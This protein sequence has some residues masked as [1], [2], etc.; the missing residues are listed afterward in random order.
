M[1]RRSRLRLFETPWCRCDATV[2][3]LLVTMKQLTLWPVGINVIVSRCQTECKCFVGCSRLH[4]WLSRHIHPSADSHISRVRA[5]ISHTKRALLAKVMT[6]D[7]AAFKQWHTDQI[8][9]S[10]HIEGRQI[11]GEHKYNV[12][13]ISSIILN[14]GA[15]RK[16]WLLWST[17]DLLI[18]TFVSKC[19]WCRSASWQDYKFQVNRSIFILHRAS[20]VGNSRDSYILYF[21]WF[22]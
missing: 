22:V 2:M 15:R 6:R 3:L 14:S 4:L 18:Y 21:R 5:Y 11:W 1:N 13:V 7:K 8:Y 10:H 19:Y 9:F 20:T 16:L 12:F 17:M